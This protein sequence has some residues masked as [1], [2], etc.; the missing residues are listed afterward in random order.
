MVLMDVVLE[1]VSSTSTT[2]NNEFPKEKNFRD[3][4]AHSFLVFSSLFPP[5]FTVF[6]ALTLLVVREEGRKEWF[7]VLTAKNT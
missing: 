5:L 1:A 2:D 4:K 6:D 7:R 3:A